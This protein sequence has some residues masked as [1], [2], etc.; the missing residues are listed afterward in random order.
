[1]CLNT[2][3]EAAVQLKEPDVT[4]LVQELWLGL[5]KLGSLFQ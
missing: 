3:T 2:D 5:T 4:L 1:M